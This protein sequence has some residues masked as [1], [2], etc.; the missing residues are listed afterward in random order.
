MENSSSNIE[1]IGNFLFKRKKNTSSGR[2]H[3]PNQV[4]LKEFSEINLSEKIEEKIPISVENFN[5]LKI[6]EKKLERFPFRK[7]D[8]SLTEFSFD[9][10]S[11]LN[12]WSLVINQEFQRAYEYY[13]NHTDFVNTCNY[14][15]KI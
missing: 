11:P 2:D 1:Q 6:S 13:S 10:N 3:F 12:I 15:S 7:S 9:D 8:I 14:N 4:I 5:N